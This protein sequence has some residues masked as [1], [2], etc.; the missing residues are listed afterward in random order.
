MQTRKSWIDYLEV[1]EGDGILPY[2]WV[3]ITVEPASKVHY[4]TSLMYLAII[5]F[6]V[7]TY[8]SL[9]SSMSFFT[10]FVMFFL[11]SGFFRSVRDG[12]RAGYNDKLASGEAGYRADRP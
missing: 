1:T 8:T 10:A 7:A 5:I 6:S 9:G 12:R 4:L 2:D 11:F 3:D